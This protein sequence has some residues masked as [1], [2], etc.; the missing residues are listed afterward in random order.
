MKYL[1]KVYDR[2]YVI[3]LEP[4]EENVSELD[5]YVFEKIDKDKPELFDRAESYIGE[6]VDLSK[7]IFEGGLALN[8]I[9]I[10][11]I[12]DRAYTVEFECYFENDDH[13]YWS[14]TFNFPLVKA[15]RESV[16]S[17]RYWPIQFTRRVE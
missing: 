2:E 5:K 1:E 3:N 10:T 11:G 6:I 15:D 14:V 9:N 16:D 17:G 8:S 13:M 7:P 4:F 12:A